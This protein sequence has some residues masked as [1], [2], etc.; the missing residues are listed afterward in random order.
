MMLSRLKNIFRFLLLGFV[1]FIY[2]NLLAQT[3]PENN[4]KKFD[5]EAAWKRVAD[6]ESKAL[7]ESQLKEVNSI[8]QQAKAENNTG[9]L[10]KAIIYQMKLTDYKEENAFVKNLN[11]IREEIKTTQFPVT[12][13][14]HSMLAEMYW[15]YYQN[16][17]WKYNNRTE[18]VNTKE[19]DIETWGLEK[20]VQE[21]ILHY[22]ASLS[23]KEKLQSADI[24]L[25]DEVLYKG[26]EEGHIL[27]PTL[28]DFLANRAIDFYMS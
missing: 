23:E 8:Y 14:L 7:P 10:V 9:Q 11:K 4:M 25:Y 21:T 1:S 17:R 19:D 26:N 28:Y 22:Q 24:K 3:N 12:P 20:I 13:L 18:T 6:F 15:Q 27:R 16:N 2:T 5:Y